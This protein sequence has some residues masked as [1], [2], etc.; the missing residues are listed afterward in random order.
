MV[1]GGKIVAPSPLAA[2]GQI[3]IGA[4]GMQDHPVP[5]AL[6]EAE[7]V[8][9]KAEFVTGAKNAVT[10]GFDGI[11]LHGANGYLLEQFLSPLTNRRTDGYGGSV[12]GRIRFVVEVA[13][14]VAAAIGGDKTAI[15]LSP[16]G[17]AGGM[18]AYP[19][20]DETYLTLTKALAAAGL[21]FVHI[22][23][24]VGMGNAP[25]PDAFRAELRKAWP[26]TLIL[27]GSLDLASAQASVDDDKIDLAGLGRTFLANPDLV[28]RLQHGLVLNPTDFSTA[29]AGGEKGYIDYPLTSEQ[30]AAA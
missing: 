6:T 2:P 19:E 10:A 1:D 14:A 18:S 7:L 4:A 15:R 5:H 25:I 21:V 24:H 20:L 29:Y 16:Y 22:A 26:R 11:E 13:Q 23:D 12:A 3:S 8:T 28:M 9:T 27:G 30:V 17:M